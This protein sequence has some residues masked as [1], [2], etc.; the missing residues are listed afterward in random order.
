LL[1]NLTLLDSE[2]QMPLMKLP[3]RSVLANL[4]TGRVL[5]SPGSR[6][7]IEQLRSLGQVDDIVANNCFHSAG[8]AKAKSVFP[9]AREWG[10]PG[11]KFPTLEE[12]TWPHNQEMP[13]VFFA[14]VPKY[15]ETVFIHKKSRT[16]ICA[17]LVFNLTDAQGFGAWMIFGMFGTYRRFGVSKFL[18]HLMVDRAAFEKSLGKLFQHDFDNILMAHGHPIIG[19]AKEKLLNALAERDLKPA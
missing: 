7:K 3:V 9:Q 17:D 2:R 5:I 6:L 13:F 4:S 10:V 12:S 11:L 15:N 1:T 16:L 18:I 14:G 8:M 19:G